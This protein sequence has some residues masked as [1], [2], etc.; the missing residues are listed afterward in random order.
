[1][2]EKE[3]S[4]CGSERGV[5]DSKERT[6]GRGQKDI[7]VLNKKIRSPEM[8]QVAIATDMCYQGLSKR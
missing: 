3:P 1:M 7:H 4:V 6:M 8:T 5:C 2:H